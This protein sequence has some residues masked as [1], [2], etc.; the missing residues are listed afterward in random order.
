MFMPNKISSVFFV[1]VMVFAA[2]TAFAQNPCTIS[3]A[4]QCGD[5]RWPGLTPAVPEPTYPSLCTTVVGS[6]GEPAGVLYAL[7]QSGSF[8]ESALDT[9]RLQNAINTCKPVQG[10][11]AVGLELALNPNDTSC[12]SAACNAFLSPPAA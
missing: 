1:L 4:S 12:G 9:T 11:A 10:T 8:N 2:A 6:N 7:Q 3:D 5:A